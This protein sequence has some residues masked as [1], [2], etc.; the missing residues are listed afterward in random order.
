LQNL[1]NKSQDPLLTRDSCLGTTHLSS[2]CPS[3]L[4]WRTLNERADRLRVRSC[5]PIKSRT[6]KSCGF[7]R[8]RDT[9][10]ELVSWPIENDRA[11]AP[12]WLQRIITDSSTIGTYTFCFNISPH[13]SYDEHYSHCLNRA[14]AWKWTHLHWK[15]WFNEPD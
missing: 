3:F 8:D 2:L 11:I 7:A 1:Y 13:A 15:F 6:Y 12:A 10:W 9:C 4:Q 5:G 14:I